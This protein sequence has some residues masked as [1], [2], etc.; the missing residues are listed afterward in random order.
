MPIVHLNPAQQ[1]V[2]GYLDGF[3]FDFMTFKLNEAF[4]RDTDDCTLF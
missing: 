2:D 1:N 3:G 4:R